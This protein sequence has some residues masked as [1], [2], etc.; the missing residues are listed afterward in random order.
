MKLAHPSWHDFSIEDSKG[1]EGNVGMVRK[2]DADRVLN[3]AEELTYLRQENT[4]LKK[5]E[6]GFRQIIASLRRSEEFFRVIIQNGGDDFIFKDINH[7]GERM[8]DLKRDDILD[9]SVLG[10]LPGFRNIGLFE[11]LQR[12]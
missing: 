6:S 4:R 8:S 1:S 3:P 10:V 11:V 12:V 2:F 9:R 5:A 7:A